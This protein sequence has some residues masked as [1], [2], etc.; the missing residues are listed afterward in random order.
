SS[1]HSSRNR[2]GVAEL[3]EI[4]IELTPSETRDAA[5]GSREL[6]FEMRNLVPPIPE[7]EQLNF[8]FTRGGARAAMTIELSHPDVEMLKEASRELQ[9]KLASFEG[10]YDIAD[11]YEKAYDEFELDL[12]PEAE[13][14]GVTASNLAQQVRTAFFGSEV[15][16]IQRGRDEI[17]VMVRYPEAER[18]SL[19]S[20]QSMMIRTANGI[21][22]PF[23]TVAEIVPGRSLPSIQRVDRKRIIQVSADGDTQ[24]LDIESMEQ[25]IL[26]VFLPEL[27]ATRYP[28]M[29]FGVR[30]YSAMARD[31]QREMILGIYFI[32]V[33][34]YALLAIP[35]RSYFQP[36][37]VMSAIPFGV[38]G[39]IMGHYI[40]AK[41]FGFNNGDPIITQR[42]IFG[43]M[44]LSGVV[45]NDSLIMVHFM[46]RKVKEGM[47]LNEAVRLAGVRRFRPILLTSLTTFFGLAPLMFETS[48]QAAD[49]VPMV[50]SLAWGIVFATAITLVLV[51]VLVLVYNDIQQGFYKLYNIKPHA[52]DDEEELISHA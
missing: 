33:V 41:V 1:F 31:N 27:A 23:E 36:I 29:Q 6:V 40:M 48:P 30:G 15:Q 28:G 7:A 2:A 51:P 46:N 12:K 32:L 25:E 37:I 5:Y 22:V 18:R 17:R 35:F 10:L 42:S 4:I 3:G 13:F 11:S 9:I 39:A 43:M 20:L 47:P 8:S 14:L 44:A 26:E 16:R 49:L 19:G 34:I 50:I 38:V 21:E 52:H 24:E 45:V